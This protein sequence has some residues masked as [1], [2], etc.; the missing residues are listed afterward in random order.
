MLILKT[1]L[2]IVDFDLLIAPTEGRSKVIILINTLQMLNSFNYKKIEFKADIIKAI[3]RTF[4]TFHTSNN[5]SKLP[6]V[7][8]FN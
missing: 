4:H 8:L 3:C 2:K 5:D 7:V 1:Q 6:F